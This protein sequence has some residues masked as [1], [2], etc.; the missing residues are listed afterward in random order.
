MLNLVASKNQYLYRRATHHLL[1]QHCAAHPYFQKHAWW[2]PKFQNIV[3]DICNIKVLHP[4]L[5]SMVSAFDRHLPHLDPTFNI[6][7]PHHLM[8]TSY[9]ILLYAFT[10][11]GATETDI[12]IAASLYAEAYRL[13]PILLNL[14]LG[15][16]SA[17][18]RK[19]AINNVKR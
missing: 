12:N 5:T 18:F 2:T 11:P 10:K 9:F 1:Y 15:S 8:A 17:S 13:C 7:D 4:L 19:A 3:F 6:F 14:R 16:F